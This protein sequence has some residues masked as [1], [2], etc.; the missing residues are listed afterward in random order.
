MPIEDSYKFIKDTTLRGTYQ[1][2]EVTATFYDYYGYR[3]TTKTV[4]FGTTLGSASSG[5]SHG[6]GPSGYVF[7]GWS[8][9]K[10]SSSTLPSNTSIMFNR[11]FYAI[12]GPYTDTLTSGYLVVGELMKKLGCTDPSDV[13]FT[14][15]TTPT[16][17][18]YVGSPDSSW[19][20]PLSKFANGSYMKCPQFQI[21]KNGNWS[22]YHVT[23]INDGSK[24]I[25]VAL[26]AK[27]CAMP[28]KAKATAYA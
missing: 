23:Q 4:Q 7:K 14:A 11:S 3:I 16:S 6:S 25:S 9:L 5:V 18:S 10:G 17:T 8:D 19:R 15:Y 28:S 22:S 1:S 2:A 12:F 26:S 13:V 27:G 21:Y 20:L 24:S